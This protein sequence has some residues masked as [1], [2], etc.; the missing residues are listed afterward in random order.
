MSAPEQNY[1]IYDKELLA[2][3]YALQN[4]RVY[5]ESCSELTIYTDH[6]NLLSFTTTKALNRRQVRWAETLGQYK[7][8]ILY[9][10]G[11]DNGRADTLSRR[12]DLMENKDIT[13]HPILKQQKDG[14][15]VPAQQLAATMIITVPGKVK[16]FQ[17]GY[18]GDTLV[19]ELKDQQPDNE[20]LEYDGKTYIPEKC[21]EQTIKDHHN[22]PAQGHPGVSKTVELL[23]R[24]Y[25]APR[26]RQ[27][28][29]R[30]IKECVMCQQNKSARHA[31]Y[32]EIQFADV[33][34][35]P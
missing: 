31:K 17:K 30:Y 28:V 33:P 15:L 5:A 10:P 16:D 12:T 3:V 8:R 13:D 27:R 11:R 1:N 29:E 2:V 20:L 7:F 21:I 18:K 32:G 22:N 19:Q 9:T 26:L 6:K 14:S 4:W 35:I 24:N 25:A 34:T 23:K